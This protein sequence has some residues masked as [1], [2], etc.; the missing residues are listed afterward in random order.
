MPI[1]LMSPIQ[2]IE[3]AA[4]KYKASR[5]LAQHKQEALDKE[6]RNMYSNFISQGMDSNEAKKL[7][8]Q[9]YKNFANADTSFEDEVNSKITALNDAK[10]AE[11]D[12]KKKQEQDAR[13]KKEQE[14]NER[15]D[16]DLAIRQQNADSNSKKADAK[17]SVAEAKKMRADKMP[18]AEQQI[19]LAQEKTKQFRA[20]AR[21][22][23]ANSLRYQYD[24]SKDAGDIADENLNSQRDAIYN[25]QVRL[26]GDE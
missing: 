17:V 18:T 2:A 3:S 7:V 6:A 5:E 25:S 13:D 8:S 20:D 12:K 21:K 22:A 23:K 16:K 4:L 24:Y 1:D 14:R 9:R 10:Q 26:G 11:I 15:K 19:T